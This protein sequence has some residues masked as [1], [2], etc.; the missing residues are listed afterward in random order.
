MGSIEEDSSVASRQREVILPLCSALMRLHWECCVCPALGSLGGQRLNWRELSGGPTRTW[1]RGWSMFSAER[2]RVL[3]LFSLEKTRLRGGLDSMCKYLQ[4]GH[5]EN[6]VLFSRDCWRWLCLSSQRLPLPTPGYLQQSSTPARERPLGSQCDLLF[7]TLR[8]CFQSVD[9]LVVAQAE[10]SSNFKYIYNSSLPF[11]V[12][13]SV[14]E[15]DQC[16]G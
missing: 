13:S 16:Y 14:W 6:R 5:K 4:W 1:W 2:A 9:V 12:K 10:V 15:V 11:G 8:S 3:E 7:S